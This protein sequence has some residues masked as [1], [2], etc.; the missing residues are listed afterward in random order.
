VFPTPQEKNNVNRQGEGGKEG[1][2]TLHAVTITIDVENAD[3]A[4][5]AH[6]LLGDAYDLLV[7]VRKGNALDGRRELPQEET[8]A[9]LHGP[10]PHLVVGRARDEEV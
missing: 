6:A 10:E 3:G 7:I 9:R 2:R 5:V 1:L 4:L 8:L